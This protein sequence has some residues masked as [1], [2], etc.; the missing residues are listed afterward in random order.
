ME[1]KAIKRVREVFGLTNVCVMVP[2]C[3][4]VEEG[5]QVVDLIREFGLNDDVP[6]YVMC[7]IP[8]NVIL[9]EQFLEI[10]DGM[11]IG[12]N[13]LTQLTLGL[14]RDNGGLAHIGNENNEAVKK[15]IRRVIKI[16]KEKNKYCGICGQAPS[17][18][19]EFARFLVE[20]GIESISLN[21]DTVIKT[22]ME[23]G[24]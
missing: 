15:L 3:R 21:A 20:E 24:K 14:D 23:L 10:F 12:S 8:S 11:S 5:K 9:A 7:E 18:Y 22:I 4:T 16:C 1:C 17:D 6:V 13:D 19:P 2:F